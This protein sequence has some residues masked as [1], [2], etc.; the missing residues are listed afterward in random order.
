LP[1]SLTFGGSFQAQ[2]SAR[3][4]FAVEGLRNRSWS[5]NVAQEQHLDLKLS[6]IVCDMQRVSDM[7]IARRLGDW[8]VI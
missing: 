2:L 4:G 8:L 1:R 5:A 6:A 3:F 7:H